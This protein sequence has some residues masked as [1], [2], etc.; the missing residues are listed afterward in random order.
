MKRVIT[1]GTFDLFHSGHVKL[2]ARLRF[3]GDELIVGLS[4][5]EFNHIK[6]KK[7]IYTYEQRKE[8]LEA[9]RYVDKVFPERCWEQKKED[10]IREG[11]HVFAMGDDWT[12][13][14]DYLNEI[15]DVIYLPRTPSISTTDIK[16]FIA[17]EHQDRKQQA[18]N[19]L[20]KLEKMISSI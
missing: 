9:C 19:T 8:I 11:A 2:L 1:Y 7:S 6:G 15:A 16:T 5:D 17:M 10:I 14:F 12:G 4:S 18:L 13:E 3:L 20:R